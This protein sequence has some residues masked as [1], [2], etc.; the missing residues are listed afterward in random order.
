M[1]EL[2]SVEVQNISGG[3]NNKG[4]TFSFVVESAVTGAG[5][6]LAIGLLFGDTGPK[7]IN[8]IGLGALIGGGYATAMMIATAVD[9]YA[10]S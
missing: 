9:N 6:G 2:N 3:F 10:F 5:Y 1:R 7:I 8:A 4:Y